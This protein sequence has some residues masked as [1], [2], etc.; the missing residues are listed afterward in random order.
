MIESKIIKLVQLIDQDEV[1]IVENPVNIRYFTQCDID[2]GC[3]ILTKKGGFLLVDDRFLLDI[4]EIDGVESVRCENFSRQLESLM[5]D[6][7]IKRV[8]LETSYVSLKRYNYYVNMLENQEI[9]Q[10]D[11]LDKQIIKLRTAKTKEEVKKIKEAQKLTDEGYHHISE[12]IKPGMTEKEIAIE[13]ERKLL[14]LGSEGKAF[15]FIVVSG[16]RTA[17]PHGKPTD[18]E[19]KKGELVTLDFGVKIDGYCSDMTRTVPVGPMNNRQKEIYNIVLESQNIAINALKVGRIGWE[20][21]KIARD[22]ITSNSYGDYFTH[23]LGHGVGLDIHEYPRLSSRSEDLIV[24]GSVVTVE[25][26]IY[27]PNEFGVRIEDMILVE[28]EGVKDLTMSSK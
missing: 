20:I 19:I 25:P 15:D 6:L 4:K 14:L 1:L 13:L 22:Y 28:D 24:S 10:S 8:F 12:Y 11:F 18:K 27:I 17:V 26:G 3:L 7:A 16:P 23:S 2:D 21:D 9:D 5:D